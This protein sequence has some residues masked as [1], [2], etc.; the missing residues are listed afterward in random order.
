M[1]APALSFTKQIVGHNGRK[2]CGKCEV[3]G[4]HIGRMCFPKIHNKL[5]TDQEFRMRSDKEHHKD[6]PSTKNLT[7]NEQD[8]IIMEHE[9]DNKGPLEEI[10]G[11]NMIDSFAIDSLHVIYIGVVKKAL[12]M[13][14]NRLKFPIN[15][16]LRTKLSKTDHHKI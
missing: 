10:K 9:N 12:S 2:A 8:E 14:S 4:K 3:V 11:V 7:E 6:Q 5:R 1:D 16:L 13:N 15:D